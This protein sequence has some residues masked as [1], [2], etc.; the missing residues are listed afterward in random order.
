VDSVTE[1][2]MAAGL[3]AGRGGDRVTVVITSSPPLLAVCDRVVLIMNGV[4]VRSATHDQLL[5]DDQYGK[6]YRAVVLR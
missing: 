2:R 6:T 5:A 4:A 1:Q 3:R